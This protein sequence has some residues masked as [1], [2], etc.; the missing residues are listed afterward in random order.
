MKPCTLAARRV[1]GVV[2]L[3]GGLACMWG[4]V[5]TAEAQRLHKVAVLTPLAET[6]PGPFLGSAGFGCANVI[7]DV[8]TSTIAYRIVFQGMNGP[9][10]NAHFHGPAAPGVPAGVMVAL[11][12]G[13]N[14]KV[15]SFVATPPQLAAF[16][17]GN[18]YIN[19]HST[20]AGGGELAG[21]WLTRCACWMDGRKR[22]RTR[23][24]GA[25]SGC[26]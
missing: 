2:G 26:S 10:T 15:G 16:L 20:F 9:Q 5:G 11:P 19:I 12:V 23:R 13:V 6:A 7:I 17:A 1:R 3:V 8:P 14:P 25:G 21:R 22:R 18:V 4:L 24:R